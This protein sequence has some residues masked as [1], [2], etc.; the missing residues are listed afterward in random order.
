MPSISSKV[1]TA[2]L[3]LSDPTVRALASPTVRR[4]PTFLLLF[5]QKTDVASNRH[6]RWRSRIHGLV[7]HASGVHVLYVCV[8][9]CV[10]F[11]VALAFVAPMRARTPWQFPLT[12][13]A[14]ARSF[15]C[16][17]RRTTTSR[18]TR[19]TRTSSA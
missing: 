9:V 2:R 17:S 14:L 18:S 15:A 6:D 12:S 8:S 7:L 10:C 3:W 1:S 16:S 5:V 11:T 19:R 4:L 13:T